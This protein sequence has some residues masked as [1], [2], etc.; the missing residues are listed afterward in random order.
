MTAKVEDSTVALMAHLAHEG[1]E[2]A[3][4]EG[5]RGASDGDAAARL[6]AEDADLHEVSVGERASS[7]PPLGA[8][9]R[10]A[11]AQ[12]TPPSASRAKRKPVPR[13]SFSSAPTAL[14]SA[15]SRNASSCSESPNA[16][17]AY[18]VPSSS[19][20][21]SYTLPSA[22]EPPKWRTQ[23]TTPVRSCRTRKTSFVGFPARRSPLSASCHRNRPDQR[24]SQPR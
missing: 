19:S 11:S 24:R 16:P 3:A 2:L 13:A 14:M 7:L 12:R 20:T 22:P 18:V 4:L 23:R 1:V 21:E 10:N 5:D 8:S 15:S 9:P 17:L 6:A